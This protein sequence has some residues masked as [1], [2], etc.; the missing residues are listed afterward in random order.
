MI[1]VI[2]GTGKVGGELVKQLSQAGVKARVLVRNAQKAEAIQKLGLE[3]AV[4]DVTQIATI[5]PALKGVEGLFLLTA[6]SLNQASE[7]IAIID[8]AKKA[9]V[10]RIVLLSAIG[11]DIQ[12]PITLAQQHAKSEE[13]LKASGVSYTI[14]RPHSFMQ[15]LLGSAPTIK[16]GALYAN[17]KD[18]KIAM[19][20]T[21]DIAA[22]ALAALTQSGHEGKTYLI[23][24]GEAVSY[25]QLGEKLSTL[26]GKSVKYVDI[27][28][29]AAS[30]AMTGFGMPEWLANDLAKL[31]EVFAAGH[32]SATTDVVEKV[33]KKKPVTVDEFLKEH[34]E[35]FK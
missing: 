2:G 33:A 26:T 19:V 12:S 4:G 14:L 21:R 5:E 35:A 10:K 22:V 25:S 17:F 23:T 8:A 16:Q 30:K 18:G 31:G 6:A 32:G 7:E 11:A 27:P 9:G 24:G 29:S 28:T 20:D 15:N 1:L 34:V 3:T 13:H